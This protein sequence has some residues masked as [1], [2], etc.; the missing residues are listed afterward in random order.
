LWEGKPPAAVRDAMKDKF[1]TSVIAYVLIKW[2]R[3]SKTQTGR[4]LSEKQFEDEKSYRNFVD[5]LL[6]KAALLTITK[7]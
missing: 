6:E 2:C 7:G 4:L 3:T 1:D 5:T